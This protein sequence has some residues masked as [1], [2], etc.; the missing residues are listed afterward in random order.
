MEFNSV[1]KGLSATQEI[2]GRQ[3]RSAYCPHSWRSSAYPPVRK[4][5]N[6][7]FQHYTQQI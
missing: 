5:F 3:I 7:V 1:F 6:R 4:G 2:Y